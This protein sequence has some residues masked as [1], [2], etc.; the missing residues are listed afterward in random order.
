MEVGESV[1]SVVGETVGMIV[2]VGASDEKFVGIMEIVG[3]PEPSV[4]KIVGI[5][6]VGDKVISEGLLVGDIEIGESVSPTG[7]FVGVFEVGESIFFV[8]ELDGVRIIFTHSPVS[9]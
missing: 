6:E 3:E 5:L 8:G 2:I 4:G 7:E 1:S 9:Q